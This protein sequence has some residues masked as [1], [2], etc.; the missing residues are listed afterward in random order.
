MHFITDNNTL[1]NFH[2]LI[3][4]YL[5]SEMPQNIWVKRKFITEIKKN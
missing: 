4:K 3:L 2:R 5:L 1:G